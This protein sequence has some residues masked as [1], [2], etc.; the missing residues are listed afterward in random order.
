MDPARILYPRRFQLS[1]I[2]SFR[3]QWAT[4]STQSQ[5]LL[6]AMLTWVSLSVRATCLPDPSANGSPATTVIQYTIPQDNFLQIQCPGVYSVAA[7]VFASYGNPSEL[8]R[9]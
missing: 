8:P 9:S 1:R 4:T 7:V 2:C 3:V 5:V 6:S